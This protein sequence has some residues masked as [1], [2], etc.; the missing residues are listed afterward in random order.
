MTE[1]DIETRLAGVEAKLAI[2]QLP[3]RYAMAVDARDFDALAE[4]YVDDVDMGQLGCGH[5]ALKAY[6]TDATAIFYRSVHQILGH[7]YELVDEDHAVG[8]VY[9]RAEHERGDQWIAAMI[10]YFDHYER[11]DGRWLF[12]RNRELDFFYCADI[13]EHPQAVD[14]QRWVLPG[15]KMDPPMMLPR[16]QNWKSFWAKHG[17]AAVDKLTTHP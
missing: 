17:Q 16:F 13:L 6:F 15:I 3:V 8:K 12:S 4:L 10:C 7:N 9:C 14:F 1:Q 2:Q 5:D 11:R